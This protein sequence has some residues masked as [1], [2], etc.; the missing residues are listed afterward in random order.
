M[1]KDAPQLSPVRVISLVLVL[2]GIALV[3]NR[4]DWQNNVATVQIAAHIVPQATST[5][6]CDLL[7]YGVNWQGGPAPA[8]MSPYMRAVANAAGASG[9]VFPAASDWA[10]DPHLF[11]LL[12]AQGLIRQGRL[13]ESLPYLRQAHVAESISASGHAPYW[14]GDYACAMFRWLVAEELEETSP[15]DT[16]SSMAESMI[17]GGQ[18]SMVVKAYERAL[19][20]QPARADWRLT[21]AQAL[22]TL[23]DWSKAEIILSPIFQDSAQER[24]SACRLLQ[25]YYNKNNL[26]ARGLAAYTCSK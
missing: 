2:T 17:I 22:L 12:E 1:D 19:A 24:P 20:Y 7:G 8:G 23:N 25:D 14:A 18:A 15:E 5:A 21:L 13:A 10:R 9:I 4:L 16:I 26:S 11:A 3:A 6:S